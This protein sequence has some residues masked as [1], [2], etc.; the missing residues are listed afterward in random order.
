MSE[1]PNNCKRLR[2]QLK[3]SLEREEQ[4]ERELTEARAQVAV[5]RGALESLVKI[6][7]TNKGTENQFV[8]CITPPHG[9]PAYWKNAINALD[10]T[11]SE[12]SERVNALVGALEFYEKFEIDIM[13]DEGEKARKALAAWRGQEN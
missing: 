4:I 5:L 9:T 10:S 6:Y 3:K 11:P 1:L 13:S 7:I 8:A 12:A 2:E